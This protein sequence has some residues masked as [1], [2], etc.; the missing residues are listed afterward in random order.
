M[1]EGLA[2]AKPIITTDTAGC[3]ETI[4]DGHNGFMVPVKNV[5]ALTQAMQKMH[6]LSP[7]ERQKMGKH[8]REMALAEFDEP[9]IIQRYLDII[10]RLTNA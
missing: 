6:A 2:M 7:K 3:R 8:G 9:I 10:R 4:K 5:E 1:L